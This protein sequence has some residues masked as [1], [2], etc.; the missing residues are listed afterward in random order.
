[1]LAIKKTR[2]TAAGNIC[3]TPGHLHWITIENPDSSTRHITLHDDND[4]TDDEVIKF[5]TPAG[6][7][8]T[9]NF[10][11]AMPFSTGIRIGAFEDSDTRVVAGYTADAPSPSV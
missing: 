11:P 9:H 3:S 8:E 1:M 6:R 2:L 7:T 5:R 10:I 4:G